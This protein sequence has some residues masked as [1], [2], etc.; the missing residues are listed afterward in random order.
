MDS[1]ILWRVAVVQVAAVTVLSLLLAL[2]FS[3]GFFESWGWLVG[4]LAW[5]ACAWLTARV[6]GLPEAPVLVR[7]A[8]SGIPSLLFVLIG[9]HWLGAAVAVAVFAAW[10]ARLPRPLA[11][12][13]S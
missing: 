11:S 10:C 8:L 2:V 5:L 12:D 7:A 3:H 4:P 6:V 9:L 1:A 13:A